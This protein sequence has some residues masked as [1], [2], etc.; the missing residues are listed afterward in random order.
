VLND[1]QGGKTCLP[2]PRTNTKNAEDANL[3]NRSLRQL[4]KPTGGIMPETNLKSPTT[5][6]KNERNNTAKSRSNENIWASYYTTK[7]DPQRNLNWPKNDFTIIADWYNSI[8]PTGITA[9]IF[10]DSLSS[11]FTTHF[12]TTKISFDENHHL[13]WSTNDSRFLLYLSRLDQLDDDDLVFFTD[14]SDV[15][16]VNH[17][18]FDKVQDDRI[19]I[20]NDIEKTPKI[21]QNDWMIAK[22]KEYLAEVPHF[23]FDAK[24]IDA[25]LYNAGIVGGN[26]K[27]A[28]EFLFKV[29]DIL[30]NQ[31]SEN[32]Y[33]MFA[34]NYAAFKIQSDLEVSSPTWLASKFKKNEVRSDVLFKHK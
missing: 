9:R 19:Y 25:K 15:T 16:I 31:V 13:P 7:P 30:S 8:R 17:G 4:A 10:H 20:G 22:T 24:F 18:Y 14:I 33:N 28:R 27:T 6:N 12:T 34:V 29:V 2:A 1:L 26:V 32:N 11:E 3:P 23:S 21:G 5:Q